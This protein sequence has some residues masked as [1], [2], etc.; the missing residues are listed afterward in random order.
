MYDHIGNLTS[1]SSVSITNVYTANNLNQYTSI[2]RDSATPREINPQYDL[3]GNM[4]RHGDWKYAYDSGCRLASVSSNDVLIASFAYETQGGICPKCGKHYA[5]EEMEGDHIVPWSKGGKT[6][7]ENLQM[8]C[9]RC[10]GLKSD[11]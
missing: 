11:K 6:V 1:D 4:T 2:L 3:D 5:I 10:N 9:R 8:L 7:P